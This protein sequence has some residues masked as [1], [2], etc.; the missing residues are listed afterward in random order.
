MEQYG[1]KSKRAGGN[2]L[3]YIPRILGGIRNR[4]HEL[5]GGIRTKEGV[6][7][8][9]TCCWSNSQF[10]SLLKDQCEGFNM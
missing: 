2:R 1:T 3:A 9:K 10:L 6:I 7:E 8:E 4:G 5:G